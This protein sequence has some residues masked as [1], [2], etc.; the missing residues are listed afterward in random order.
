[1]TILGSR[2]QYCVNQNAK[3]FDRGINE[4]CNLMLGGT[5]LTKIGKT[6]VKDKRHGLF[7]KSSQANLV[8]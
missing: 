3:N 4:A 5:D 6:N 2:E 7:S 1:M 8:T